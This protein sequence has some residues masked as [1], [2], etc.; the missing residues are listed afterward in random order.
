MKHLL[1]NIPPVHELQKENRFIM[2]AE[3]HG[4]DLIYMTNQLKMVLSKIREELTLNKWLGAIPGS[5][6]FNDEIFN[7]LETTLQKQLNYTLKRVIN[8][9]GTILHTNLG[10]ARLSESAAQ[11]MLE[12]ALHYSNLEYQLEE[13]KRG[14]RHS[15]VEALIKELTGAEAAMVVNNNAAAVYLILK[16]I[17]NNKEVVVS[18]GQLV[19]IGGSFRISSIMEESGAK[20]VEIGTTNKTHLADYEN[21]ITEQTAMILKVHTSNYKVIG[22]TKTVGTDELAELSREKN[23]I[24]YEDLGSGALYDFQKHGIGEEPVVKDV[25]KQGADLVSFSGDKLLGGPQAGIIA[26]KKELISLLKKHQLSR[27]LRV[28]KMTLAALEGTLLDYVK[29]MEGLKNIPVIRDI[30]VSQKDLKARTEAF[31]KKL[32]SVSHQYDLSIRESFAQIGGGTM[33]E[34]SLPSIVAV[35]KHN[36]WGAEQLAKKLRTEFSSSIIVRI[37]KEEVLI[38]L[39]TVTNEEEVYI[40]EALQAI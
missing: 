19:E 39:R 24:L 33:P 36:T 37:Q 23:I 20:L 14:S 32:Q 10:R 27:V 5:R 11:H 17:A 38:D 8:T 29:G 26:G 18:R 4:I 9:T 31:I 12:I 34:V 22:F 7:R 13:G 6:D 16:A 3:N 21:A 28:D 25:I 2:L 40:I 1:R 35:I 30:L 15:H